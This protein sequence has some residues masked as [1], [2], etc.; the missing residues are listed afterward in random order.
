[1]RNPIKN[2]IWGKKVGV[3]HEKMGIWPQKRLKMVKKIDGP[4]YYQ[5]WSKPTWVSLKYVVKW[6]KTVH[7]GLKSR[8]KI[9][10]SGK[11]LFQNGYIL[12]KLVQK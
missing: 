6:V 1:M 9:P 2:Q 10:Q 5:E 11:K 7:N 12:S 3:T 4:L 8:Q